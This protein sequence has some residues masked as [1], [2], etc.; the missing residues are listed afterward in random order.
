[1]HYPTFLSA[2]VSLGVLGACTDR[3]T[4]PTAPSDVAAL[5]AAAVTPATRTEFAGFNHFCESIPFEDVRVTPGG[6]LHLQGARNR[7]QWV[8]GNPL[9]D[10]FE[11]NVVDG[12]INLRTG[13][14]R[15]NLELTLRPDAVEGAWEIRST[16]EILG[17]VPAGTSGVGH[18]TGEL[19]GMTIQF[20]TEPVGFGQNI[21]NP[22][23]ASARVQGVIISP[24][25][26]D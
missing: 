6:T 19:Q 7:N 10:G 22:G 3:R 20:T 11:E 5:W 8:T 17:G 13:T 24:A 14:G 12:N 9:I 21:C 18:G 1:M 4:S 2:I 23:R 16:V 15:G 26:P 25:T